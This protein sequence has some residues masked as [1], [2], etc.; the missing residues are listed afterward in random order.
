MESAAGARPSTF[1]WTSD[2]RIASRSTVDIWMPWPRETRR[3]VATTCERWWRTRSGIEQPTRWRARTT[4]GWFTRRSGSRCLLDVDVPT[5]L[6]DEHAK[7]RRAAPP[8]VDRRAPNMLESA[9][10]RKA[11][12]AHA[13][14]H[15]HVDVGTMRGGGVENHGGV[16]AEPQMGFAFGVAP[17]SNRISSSRRPASRQTGTDSRR[18]RRLGT[19]RSWPDPIGEA[20]SG[21]GSM[22]PRPCNGVARAPQHVGSRFKA[23]SIFKAAIVKEADPVPANRRAHS[24]GFGRSETRSTLPYSRESSGRRSRPASRELTGA[25]ACAPPREM[26]VGRRDAA[27]S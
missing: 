20:F 18:R 22:L 4:I 23:T 27:G 16:I 5:S 10:P 6:G 3:S 17:S 9:R 14:S 11:R 12:E 13:G 2:W 7:Q 1:R 26:P 15:E 8:I 21:V 25:R 24:S 19:G